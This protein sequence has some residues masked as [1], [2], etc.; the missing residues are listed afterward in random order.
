MRKKRMS[1]EEVMIRVE[2][3]L[4]LGGRTYRNHHNELVEQ[5]FSMIG[6]QYQKSHRCGHEG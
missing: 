6:K 1:N 2:L 3:Y 5:L 4:A